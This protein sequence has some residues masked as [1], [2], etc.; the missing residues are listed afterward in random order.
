MNTAAIALMRKC[1]VTASQALKI[2]II[3]FSGIFRPLFIFCFSMFWS[4]KGPIALVTFAPKT[5]CPGT[6]KC[7][8]TAIERS[9]GMIESSLR[10]ALRAAVLRFPRVLGMGAICTELIL[11]TFAV[12]V[13]CIFLLFYGTELA[14]M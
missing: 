5:K 7:K 13:P 12:L 6:P 9:C 14:W 4:K 3:R 10:L 8:H 1:F 2:I 11:V